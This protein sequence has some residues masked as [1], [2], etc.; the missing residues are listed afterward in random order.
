M[1]R[2]SG[3]L[4]ANHS[5]RSTHP[6]SLLVSAPLST[7]LRRFAT[8][9]NAL[10]RFQRLQHFC[11]ACNAFAT[12]AKLATLATLCNALQCFESLCIALNR[13]VSPRFTNAL[14][15]LFTSHRITLQ[16]LALLCNR[17]ANA[18]HHSATR[19]KAPSHRPYVA[20]HRLASLC[21]ALHCVASLCIALQRLVA[22]HSIAL[23]R[24]PFLC[25][26][27]HCFACSYSYA[28]SSSSWCKF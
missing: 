6:A 27:L 3:L 17:F 20:M 5:V 4:V 23:H 25:I 22:S 12:L 13:F 24:T 28:T 8:L 14:R 11:N 26:S 10:Q 18:L 21:I 16:S 7:A 15:Y 19:C 2:W 1:R 9:C